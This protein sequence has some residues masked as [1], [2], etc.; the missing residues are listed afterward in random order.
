MIE[1]TDIVC[2]W[3]LVWVEMEDGKQKIFIDRDPDIPDE[4]VQKEIEKMKRDTSLCLK[5]GYA[6]TDTGSI[7]SIWRTIASSIFPTWGK[8]TLSGIVEPNRRLQM[9][10]DEWTLWKNN[11]RFQM[12]QYVKKIFD[13]SI[14]KDSSVIFMPWMWR[15]EFGLWSSFQASTKQMYLIEGDSK[16]EEQIRQKYPH[17][18]HINS[19]L[20]KGD[21][22]F[23]QELIES[24][25]GTPVSILSF[26]TE[27]S[28]TQWLI[29]DLAWIIGNIH[30][31]NDLFFMVNVV[32]RWSYETAKKIMKTLEDTGETVN[33]AMLSLPENLIDIS[34]RDDIYVMDVQSGSYLWWSSSSMNYVF[35]HIQKK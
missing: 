32:Q 30:I 5:N 33:A 13:R 16:K 10:R 25:N 35:C 20:W 6:K 26:D 23:S 4:E 1:I 24:L 21:E 12:S 31:Q 17:A 2:D 29:I 18:S 3:V 34:G 11:W 22:S 8:V 14:P 27:V 28:L 9:L 7:V 19:F 15:E